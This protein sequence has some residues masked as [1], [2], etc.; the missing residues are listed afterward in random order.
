MNRAAI[1]VYDSGMGGL[2]V[3]RELRRLLPCESLIYL[4][5][6]KN[7]PYGGRSREEIIG[8]AE[9]AVERLL[10]EGVKMVV[11]GC[12]TATTAAI[13]HLRQRW[14]EL[15][16]VGLEPA[17]KPACLATRSRKIAVLATEHSLKSDMFLRTASR[18]ADDV[19][20]LK[21]VGRD[22]VE[23]VEESE[24]H[25]ERAERAVRSVVEPLLTEGVDKIVLG[26]T[27]YP[28][29]RPLIEDV[30]V[31]HD[32]EVIDSGE[33]VA[34]RVKWLLER[35]DIA[36]EEG[37]ESHLSFLTFHTEEYRL[38][39]ERKAQSILEQMSK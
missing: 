35:Y 4:G 27:H 23:I 34:R 1:G 15:P 6:G 38:L 24:E 36:A 17:V 13:D 14:P 20:V 5:D 39:L 16:I 18:Y 32:I 2:S 11:V 21:V 3:W 33:A 28:F 7:C 8:F 37:N 22:F 31:G 12:N 30:V 9:A 29:L 10:T 25:S 19:E 26:C